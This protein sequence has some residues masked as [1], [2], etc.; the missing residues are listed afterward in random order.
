VEFQFRVDAISA[1]K[2]RYLEEPGQYNQPLYNQQRYVYIKQDTPS[3]YLSVEYDRPIGRM[4]HICGQRMKFCMSR[5]VHIGKIG[6][7]SPAAIQRAPFGD[8]LNYFEQFNR[9]L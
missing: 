1:L 2:T 8:L 7:V 6:H 3:I 9:D 5:P 4:Q